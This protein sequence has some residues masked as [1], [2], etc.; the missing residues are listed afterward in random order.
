MHP[1]DDPATFRL[2]RARMLGHVARLGAE[3]GRAWAESSG[4]ELPPAYRRPPM[5]V[6]AGMGGS[7]A[8]GDYLATL[9][10]SSGTAPVAVVRDY[11]LPAYCGESCLVVIVSYSGTTEEAIACYREARRRGS[12]V[13]V[14]SRGGPL[15]AMATRDGVPFH[16]VNYDSPPRAALGHALAAVLRLAATAGVVLVTDA[17][18]ESAATAHARLVA[19]QLSERVQ[20]DANPAKRAAA[21]IVDRTPMVLAAD[22]LIA[23]GLRMKNQFAEN[24]KLLGAFEA[25]PEATHNIPVGLEGRYRGK[26]SAIVLDSPFSAPGNRRRAEL[27]ARMCADAGARVVSITTSGG[28]ILGDLLEA[29]A[30]GDYLSCYVALLRGEDPTPTVNLDRIREA[31]AGGVAT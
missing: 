30:W 10:R 28:S 29:T 24:A 1:L 26:G 15:A 3:L 31:M 17:D 22:P 23:A 6:V 12:R 2:D 18:V 20:A 27:M 21:D 16:A 19:L 13:V 5:M 8:A 4:F 25:L 9:A 14:I 7:A 11:A